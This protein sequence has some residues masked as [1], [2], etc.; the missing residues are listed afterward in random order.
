VQQES[1]REIVDRL[2]RFVGELQDA[3]ARSI[4]E[5]LCADAIF[6]IWLAHPFTEFVMPVDTVITTVASQALYPLPT[7]FGRIASKEGVLRNLD[8]GARITPETGVDLER[9]HPE[10]GGS[11]DTQTADPT[12][13]TITGKVGVATQVASAGEALEAVSSDPADSDVVL[14]AEGLDNNGEWNTSQVQLTGTAAKPL[15][16]WKYVQTV[17]KAY[18]ATATPVTALTSSRG[19]VTVRKVAGATRVLLLPHESSREHYQ[20]RLWR[21]PG[22]V[23]RIGIPT[24]RLP[25]R[26]FQDADPIPAMWGPAVFERMHLLWRVNRGELSLESAKGLMEDGYEFQRLIGYDN[27]LKPAARFAK[28][29]FGA[30]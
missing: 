8:T 15:G 27:E 17:A 29:P 19:T 12:S 30:H 28:R 13:Y 1:R 14:E 10:I 11:T 21:T 26:L 25:R 9:Q 2:L 20:L 6:S 3:D 22:Q 16:T 18:Q 23:R 24:I 5:D 4:A 7:Y